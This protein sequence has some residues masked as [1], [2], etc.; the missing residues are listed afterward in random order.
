MKT[1][2]ETGEGEEEVFLLVRESLI[3]YGAETS[4]FLCFGVNASFVLEVELTEGG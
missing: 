3:P 4:I 2:V 1:T